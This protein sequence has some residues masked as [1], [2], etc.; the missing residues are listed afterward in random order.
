MT[1]YKNKKNDILYQLKVVRGKTGAYDNCFIKLSCYT[2]YS[3]L[4]FSAILQSN[5]I[6]RLNTVL[7]PKQTRAQA[8]FL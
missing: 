8:L 5:D 4:F 3:K 2:L 6:S 7:F 1:G